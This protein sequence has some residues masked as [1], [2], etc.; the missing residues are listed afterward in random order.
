MTRMEVN[1]STRAIFQVGLDIV[2][3]LLNKSIWQQGQKACCIQL[4]P[5]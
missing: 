5:T 2:L 1:E 4:E 3:Y